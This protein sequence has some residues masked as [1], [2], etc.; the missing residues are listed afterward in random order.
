M[1]ENPC[2]I[3]ID[4]NGWSF[5]NWCCLYKQ[6]EELANHILMLGRLA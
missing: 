4:E 5:V 3:R 1:G 6:D 2:N